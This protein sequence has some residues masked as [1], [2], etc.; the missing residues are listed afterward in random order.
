MFLLTHILLYI[1]VIIYILT[2][3]S[4]NYDLLNKMPKGAT[5]INT[6]RKEVVDED[7]LAKLMEERADF[8]YEN[9]SVTVEGALKRL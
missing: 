1:F 9:P 3:K 8:K 4:I 6:A 2:K 5:L 7:S